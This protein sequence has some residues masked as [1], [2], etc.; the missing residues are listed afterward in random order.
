MNTAFFEQ[1][2][3]IIGRFDPPWVAFIL[4]VVILCFKAPEII[5]A[6]RGKR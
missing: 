6:L 3:V 2:I 4:A 1:L 5:R